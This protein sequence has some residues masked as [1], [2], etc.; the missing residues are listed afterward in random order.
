MNVFTNSESEILFYAF[1]LTLFEL[2]PETCTLI[3]NIESK[4]LKAK[5]VK[6]STHA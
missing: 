1:F 2:S 6:F 5:L 3:Q 4:T